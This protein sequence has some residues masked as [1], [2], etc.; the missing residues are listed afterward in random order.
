M[1]RPFDQYSAAY[2]HIEMHRQDGIIELTLHSA[3]ASLVWGAKPHEELGYA[4]TEVG[5][6]RSNRV[7]ILTGAGESWCSEL[8]NSWV[9]P[10]TPTKW[11]V[12]HANGRRLLDA[13]LGIEVPVVAVVNGPAKVHAEIALLADIVIAAD[14]A[15]FQDAPHFRYGTVPS[16]G[17]H[18]IWPLLLGPNRARYFLLTGQRL[19]AAEA[20]RLGVVGEV[21]SA[22]LALERGW[23]LARELALQDDITLRLTRAA[24]THQLK[25]TLADSLHYGLAL[26]GLGAHATW[27]ET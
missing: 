9:G 12:I 7:V 14:T 25:R 3:G 2:E 20:L 8:D 1:W 17:V 18:I 4:F 21:V 23:E 11:D 26:E 19:S 24:L 16:D 22:P 5:A 13:L 6:D 27:P 10:M 15:F